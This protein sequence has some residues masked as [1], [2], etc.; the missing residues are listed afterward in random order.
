MSAT[1]GVGL[2]SPTPGALGRPR[3]R[4]WAILAFLGALAIYAWGAAPSV[5]DRDTGELQAVALTG[6]VAHTTGYPTFAMVGWVFGQMLPGDPAG[7]INLMSSFFGA[8]SLALLVVIGVELSLAPVVAFAGAMIYGAGFS[9]WAGAERAE[10]Y[11]LS[12]TLFLLAWWRTLVALRTDRTRDRVTAAVLLGL[13]LTGHLAS[14]PAVAVLGLSLAWRVLRLRRAW[15]EW[16]LLVLGLLVGLLPYLH[17]PFADQRDVPMNYLRLA[18][19]VLF[20]ETGVPTGAF[21]EPWYRSW[22]LIAGLTEAPGVA[23]S[24][25]VWNVLRTMVWSTPPVVLF[26]MGPVAA[27]LAIPGFLAFRSERRDE[28]HRITLLVAASYLFSVVIVSGPLLPIFLLFALAPVSLLAARGLQRVL[29]EAV[30]RTRPWL[31]PL[32]TCGVM[33]V[34]HALRLWS[35]DHPIGPRRWRV[36]DEGNDRP[37]RLLQ[38]FDRPYAARDF[39]LGVLRAVPEQSL[40]LG[41][42]KELSVLFYYC[43]ALGQRRDLTLH[44]LSEPSCWTVVRRWEREHDLTRQPAVYLSMT[45]SLRHVLVD[46][47]SVQVS[48]GAWIYYSHAPIADPPGMRRNP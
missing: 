17:I 31:L 15:R 28:A 18:D 8:V 5:L 27:L 47:E 38:R 41:D 35:Y 39:G 20:P 42:W 36:L 26:E 48:P 2:P 23:P 34:P 3:V 4:S 30:S 37:L 44:P 6:G 40:V 1:A 9:F 19:R 32:A 29:P 45:P 11:T 12:V 14:A 10:V 13:T 16:P 7:R 25:Q 22:W 46:A 43:N 24:F 21:S 33:L